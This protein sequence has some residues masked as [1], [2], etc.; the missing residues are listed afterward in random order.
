MLVTSFLSISELLD[1]LRDGLG[2]SERVSSNHLCIEISNS[3]SWIVSTS[4]RENTF[5]LYERLYNTGLRFIIQTLMNRI[6]ESSTVDCVLFAIIMSLF[7][8]YCI[9][10]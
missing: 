2:S 6:Y 8:L 7:Y 3:Q 10:L 5:F 1:S 9:C 4:E